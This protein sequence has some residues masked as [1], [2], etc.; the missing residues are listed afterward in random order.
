MGNP[1]TTSH[2]QFLATTRFAGLDGLRAIAILLV[3]WHHTIE[4]FAP[5]LLQFSGAGYAGVRLFFVISGFLITTLLLREHS[6]RGAISLRN[7]YVRRV[8]R[9]MPLYYT[10][11]VLYVVVIAAANLDP[12]YEANF[13]EGLPYYA[14]F[15]S[16]FHF[17]LHC[18]FRQAWSLAAEEQFYLTWPILLSVAGSRR[19]GW[20][21]LALLGVVHLFLLDDV[22]AALPG[23]ATQLLSRVQMSILFGVGLAYTLHSR[24]GH[25]LVSSLLAGRAWPMVSLAALALLNGLGSR[26]PTAPHHYM[27]EVAGLLVVLCCLLQPT[28]IAVRVLE[29]SPM[30]EVGLYSYGIYMLHI[31]CILAVRALSEAVGVDSLALQTLAVVALSVAVGRVSYYRFERPFLELK[32]RFGAVTPASNASTAPRD[33]PG[34]KGRGLPTH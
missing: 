29:S 25:R 17:E 18:H 6:Q 4:V 10:T 12:Q 33:A 8:L 11:I 24:R 15:T 1:A 28:S 26:I 14:T 30:S 27:L 22:R 7:F 32:R 21:L 13:F 9:I 23:R 31:L 19:A 5:A 2:D 3:I 34:P 16:N 20:V